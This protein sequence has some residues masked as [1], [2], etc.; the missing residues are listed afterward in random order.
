MRVRTA[1]P[2]FFLITVISGCSSLE[3]PPKLGVLPNQSGIQIADVH[4][5]GPESLLGAIGRPPDIPPGTT[6]VLKR[7]QPLHNKEP[8]YFIAAS[9][10]LKIVNMQNASKY[11][12]TQNVEKWRRFFDGSLSNAEIHKILEH[13]IAEI[14]WSNAGRCFHA[15]LQKHDF[16]WGNAILFLTTY[17][18]G[19]TGGPVNNDMLVLVVQGFTSDGKYAVNGHFEISHPK[20]PTNLWD[21]RS[22]KKAVFSIDDETA[23]AEMWLNR[24]PDKSFRPTIQAYID[25]LSALWIG[26]KVK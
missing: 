11:D 25:F 5:H 24:Q 19:K 3:S 17:V 16:P 12:L 2:L 22:R 10:S 23:Q 18:Q 20:L 15:K 8:R 6:L 13:Q 21:E 9:G 4:E 1:F 26:Q 7:I 14:P